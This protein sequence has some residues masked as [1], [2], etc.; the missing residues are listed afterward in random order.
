MDEAPY[1]YWSRSLD[2]V[3]I[4]AVLRS[5]TKWFGEG[6]AEDALPSPRLDVPSFTTPLTS[7]NIRLVDSGS[8]GKRLDAAL[9]C[10][11]Q[12]PRPE[13]I[14]LFGALGRLPTTDQSAVLSRQSVLQPSAPQVE[15]SFRFKLRQTKSKEFVKSST[16]WGPHW[17]ECLGLAW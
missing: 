16:P 15:V 8:L 6:D 5:S 7:N 13:Q 9:G 3:L 17:C 2:V 14:L 1:L 12:D 10:S 11:F 4:G